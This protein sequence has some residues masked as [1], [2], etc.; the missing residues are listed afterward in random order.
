MT[1]KPEL[2]EKTLEMWYYAKGAR[3][4]SGLERRINLLIDALR[5]MG[6]ELA[7]EKRRITQL[8]EAGEGGQKRIA[9]LEQERDK[10][11]AAGEELI[12]NLFKANKR[13]VEMEQQL[14]AAKQELAFYK[15]AVGSTS[16]VSHTPV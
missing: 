9:E 11:K 3:E 16:T 15:P 6:Q 14:A 2:D 12:D 8:V 1:D 13:I 10:L 7:Y 5:A 4:V